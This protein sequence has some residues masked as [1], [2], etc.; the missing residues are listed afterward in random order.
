MTPQLM[1]QTL[2]VPLN[3]AVCDMKLY[4]IFS[5][6]LWKKFPAPLAYLKL[7]MHSVFL[8]PYPFPNKT[9]ICFPLR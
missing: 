5:K 1:G 8:L 9:L 4:I 6:H 3:L 2:R 7:F